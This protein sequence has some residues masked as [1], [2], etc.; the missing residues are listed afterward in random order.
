MQLIHF[1][2]TL[3]PKHL[4]PCTIQLIHNDPTPTFATAHEFYVGL[5]IC[6]SYWF[7]S[8]TIAFHPEAEG[9]AGI[10]VHKVTPGRDSSFT[11]VQ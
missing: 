7:K 6:I 10:C 5:C 9:R 2:A 4:T 3:H 8:R 1:G 11:G